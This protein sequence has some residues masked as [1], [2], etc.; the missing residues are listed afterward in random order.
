M[1]LELEL[2]QGMDRD[3]W[4]GM[5]T[6]APQLLLLEYIN[7]EEGEMVLELELVQGMDMVQYMAF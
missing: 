3:I 4:R 1:V 2:V 5:D 6:H 7:G